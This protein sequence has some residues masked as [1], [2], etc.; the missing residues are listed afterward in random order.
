M[1]FGVSMTI[2]F[3]EFNELFQKVERVDKIYL[4]LVELLTEFAKKKNFRFIE[5]DSFGPFNSEVL[6]SIK[7]DIKKKVKDFDE[8]VFHLPSWEINISAYE[9]QV[10]NKSIEETKKNIK[11]A[12]YIGAKKLVLHPGSFGSSPFFYASFPEVV[13]KICR[14][15]VLDLVSYS[16]KNGLEVCLENLPFGAPFFRK[17]KDFDYFVKKGVSLTLDTAHSIT[18]DIDPV[19]FIDRFK[20]KIR[21]VHLVDGLKHEDDLH[22]P[23]G[24]GD[25]D[26]KKF[27]DKLEKIEYKEI[28][29]LELMSRKDTIKSIKI[30]KDYF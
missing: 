2:L 22:Y 3:K 27:L 18:A 21:H 20:N 11:I 29:I 26:Y 23:I 28:I 17:P 15:S 24:S 4:E 1:K 8:V 12:K 10:R 25:L 9:K 19:M 6:N 5:I 16:K 30:L 13:K 7:I 14:K